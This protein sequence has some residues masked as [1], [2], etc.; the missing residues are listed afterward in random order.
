MYFASPNGPAGAA[1]AFKK[2]EDAIAWQLKGRKFYGTMVGDSGEYR[3]NMTISPD[4]DIET[5]GFKTW[6]IPGGKYYREKI[7]D[8]EKHVEEIAPKCD[9][10]I[11]K[12][13]YDDTRPV[14]EYYRSQAE[15][16]IL[17]PIK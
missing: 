9:E 16:H 4:D 15:L 5:L 13:D 14:I 12:T 1:A 2:L 3:A 8:W 10:I 17:V 7:A 11:N 6:T